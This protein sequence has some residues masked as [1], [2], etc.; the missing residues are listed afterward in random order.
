MSAMLDTQLGGVAL[1]LLLVL[2]AV[3]GIGGVLIWR[4]QRRIRL[5]ESRLA[6][7]TQSLDTARIHADR[8]RE[9]VETLLQDTSHRI[10]NSL[11][12][13][14]SLLGLQM[15]RSRSEEVKQALEAARSRVHAIASAHRRLRLG[16]DL[17]TANA[18]D[19]LEAVLEDLAR[20][21]SSSKMVALVGEVDAIPISAR[22]ATTLGILI[23]ELVSNALKHGYPDSRAGRI[24][25][26]LQRDSVGVPILSVI[27]DGVGVDSPMLAGEGGLGSVIVKQL[28]Q[29]FGGIPAYQQRETGGLVVSV[30][31]PGLT[32]N[33]SAE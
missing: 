12:T 31:M 4:Q 24:L 29:Q 20:T 3:A 25:V 14:S 1:A 27:D 17:E 19:F 28:A 22:H 6:G 15:L 7:L 21:T 2:A 18:G 10:G 32:G 5:L 26:R 11:A 23:G 9:R 33:A 30:P 8:E 16:D 13:V